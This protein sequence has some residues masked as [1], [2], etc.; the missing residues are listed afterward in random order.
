MMGRTA[1]RLPVY[2]SNAPMPTFDLSDDDYGRLENDLRQSI[3]V[4]AR[5]ALLQACLTYL[6]WRD[7]EIHADEI[8]EAH[9]A[10]GKTRKQI[11][12]FLEVGDGAIRGQGEAGEWIDHLLFDALEHLPIALT[13]RD[14][15]PSGLD[16]FLSKG[17]VDAG[18]HLTVTPNFAMRLGIALRIAVDQVEAA[19]A[20]AGPGFKPGTAFQEWL[21]D[22][23][24]WAVANS[25]RHGAEDEG[26]SRFATFLYSLHGFFPQH[27]R[28][29]QMLSAAAM[30][31]R[32]R[33]SMRAARANTVES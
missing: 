28:E 31:T 30:N 7:A 26:A 1:D 29:A 2:S 19:I 14:L 10:W 5:P 11:E 32:L 4:Q 17:H 25:L 12:A 27:L 22:M 6:R 24:E 16:P 20:G 18:Q 8:K 33:R 23:R 3:P 9:A 13:E 21:G 15:E